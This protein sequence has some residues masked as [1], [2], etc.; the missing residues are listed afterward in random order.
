MSTIIIVVILA[1]L[2]TITIVLM[3]KYRANKNI[4][5]PNCQLEFATD[6]FLLQDKALL[7]CPFC[8]RWVLVTELFEKYITK[9]LFTL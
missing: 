1:L 8:H 9:K 6:L 2:V 5:C 3:I 7:V 4:R